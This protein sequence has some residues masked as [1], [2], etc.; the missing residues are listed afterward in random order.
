MGG[1]RLAIRHAVTIGSGTTEE[2]QVQIF[3]LQGPDA[4]VLRESE[5]VPVYVNPL[6]N[7]GALL[8]LRIGFKLIGLSPGFFEE[9]VYIALCIFRV[10]LHNSGGPVL[11][12]NDVLR[13]RETILDFEKE[14]KRAIKQHKENERVK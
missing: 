2:E 6:P 14:K 13:A 4:L 12:E 10:H 5:A 9:G 11:F 3:P 7:R 8:E 1:D